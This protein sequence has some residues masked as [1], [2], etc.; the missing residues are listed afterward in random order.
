MSLDKTSGAVMLSIF[1]LLYLSEIGFF[2]CLKQGNADM[3][4]KLNQNRRQNI[5]QTRHPIQKAPI[6]LAS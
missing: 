2:K 4:L 5:A 3:V 6:P 1:Y